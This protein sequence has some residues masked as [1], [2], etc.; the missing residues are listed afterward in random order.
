MSVAKPYRLGLVVGKFAPFHHG[1]ELVIH[2]ARECC[3]QV[4]VLGYSQ[5]E[6]AGCERER[7][8]AEFRQRR[9]RHADRPCRRG[10]RG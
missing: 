6:F 10:R 7:R 4:L 3:E 2:T 8:A 1:H 9:Q 5:P